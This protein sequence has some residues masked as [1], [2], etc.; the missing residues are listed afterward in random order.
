MLITKVEDQVI[1]QAKEAT[2]NLLSCLDI[3]RWRILDDFDWNHFR[4]IPINDP[5]I[6]KKLVRKKPG[7]HA[8]GTL[9]LELDNFGTEN[10]RIDLVAKFCYTGEDNPKNPKNY[11]LWSGSGSRLYHHLDK[12]ITFLKKM[13]ITNIPFYQQFNV[14]TLDKNI[15][16]TFYHLA[17]DLRER[18]RYTL[19]DIDEFPFE[20]TLN[21]E[22]VRMDV[23]RI[24]NTIISA[25][26]SGEYYL[27][28]DDHH[29]AEKM[30]KA[31]KAI[32]RI[33]IGR[34]DNYTKRGD[35]VIGDL[36]HIALSDSSGWDVE[37]KKHTLKKVGLQYTGPQA[38]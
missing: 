1:K 36:D 28:V 19:Y 17:V 26:C 38:K 31:H 29:G 27:D 9:V 18:E 23:Q 21:G 34:V 6:V 5:R 7:E 13:G 37:S 15:Y 25:V 35:V 22:D 8:R 3:D 4:V 10:D 14:D 11:Q 12:T 33:M 16:P 30:D 24:Q 20:Q 2:E 32:E